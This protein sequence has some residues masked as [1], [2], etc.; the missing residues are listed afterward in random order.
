VKAIF[1]LWAVLCLV[2]LPLTAV[3]CDTY[4]SRGE[5]DQAATVDDTF[6]YLDEADQNYGDN[7]L[8]W[9]TS[10]VRPPD[11]YLKRS[12]LIRFDLPDFLYSYRNL[13]LTDATLHLYYE[14]LEGMTQHTVL[15][16]DLYEVRATRTWTE[17]GA[18]WDTYDGTNS[19]K[20]DGCQSSTDDRYETSLG[21]KAFN[22]STT[23]PKEETWNVLSSLLDWKGG[24]TNNGWV[25]DGTAISSGEMGAVGAKFN[26]SDN[27]SN[28]PY[29]TFSY[30]TTPT[31]VIAHSAGT[32]V[33]FG[34]F[35]DLSGAGSYDDD[36][37]PLGYSWDLDGDAKADFTT[38]TL[39]LSYDDLYGLIGSTGPHTLALL[40]TDGS[41][42]GDDDFGAQS[43]A[44][45]DITLGAQPPLVPEAGSLMLALSG[46]P[47]GL[48]FLR[49]RLRSR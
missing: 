37:D 38:A 22:A 7:S 31:A 34:E 16:V 13:T 9:V 24:A 17:M 29:L 21:T 6:M 1:T 19:W 35:L 46:A 18:T 43:V 48:V 4:D 33:N 27:A 20:T 26:S 5:L 40:V 23:V 42:S 39:H 36:L 41:T 10:Q 45:L 47:V 3:W 12:S 32:T 2:A 14:G 44:T 15:N 8:L 25:L 28:K 30:Y 49:R 11:T